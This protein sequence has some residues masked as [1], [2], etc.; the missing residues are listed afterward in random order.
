MCDVRQV[1]YRPC[2]RLSTVHVLVFV[3]QNVKS[4]SKGA[5]RCSWRCRLGTFSAPAYVLAPFLLLPMRA[6]S[7][8]PQLSCRR[9]GHQKRQVGRC[10]RRRPPRS[11]F[12][13]AL[14][15][16]IPVAAYYI[17]FGLVASRLIS[18][19]PR[20]R[21]KPVGLAAAPSP[22]RLAARLIG[23]Y[24]ARHA[25]RCCARQVGGLVAH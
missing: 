10:V 21:L 4:G 12:L 14:H 5:R 22:P 6:K 15:L 24:S 25:G 19:V 7:R 16:L 9:M 3:F 2:P 23:W 8:W 17:L 13:R 18:C 1:S 11:S 20:R